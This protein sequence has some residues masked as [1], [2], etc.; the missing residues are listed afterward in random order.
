M[1]MVQLNGTWQPAGSD[2]VVFEWIQ[3]GVVSPNTL[4]RHASW[5]SPRSL[6]EVPVFWDYG[7]RVQFH[8]A[9]A[10]EAGAQGAAWEAWGRQQQAAREAGARKARWV[11]GGAGALVAVLILFLIL[12]SHAVAAWILLLVPVAV[13]G[14][15]LVGRGA[16][17]PVLGAFAGQLRTHWKRVAFGVAITS[18]A[19]GFALLSI[20]D[21]HRTCDRS[22]ASARESRMGIPAPPNDTVSQWTALRTA[23]DDSRRWCAVVD[24]SHEAELDAMYADAV[25]GLKVAE[26]REA[27]EADVERRRIAEE[28]AAAEKKRIA[29]IEAAFPGKVAGLEKQLVKVDSLFIKRD[30]VGAS[31]TLKGVEAKLA[32]ASTTAV[33]SGADFKK[34]Q[35]RAT[36]QRDKLAPKLAEIEKKEADRRQKAEIY[37][38]LCGEQPV[39]SEWDGGIFAVQRSVMA[40]AHDPDS[41][42]VTECTVPRLTNDNCWV[43]RC[44]VRGKNAFGGTILQLNTYS[45]STLGASELPSE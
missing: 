20:R 42:D 7:R 22:L 26:A 13:V 14:A 9:A 17:V 23:V 45:I 36:A 12:R 21:D 35:K 18:L 19:S 41:I 16:N 4:I 30:F 1:W 32:E 37:A 11:L 10:A 27:A 40:Y 43:S 34:L 5:P 29:D 2:A 39:P 6:R 3:R 33:A 24:T 15:A 44:K 28:A 8:A 31:D 38:A 25:A